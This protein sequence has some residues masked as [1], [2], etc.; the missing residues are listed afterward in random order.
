MAPN[1]NHVAGILRQRVVG[2]YVEVP[3]MTGIGDSSNNNIYLIN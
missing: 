1:P 2:G 3:N